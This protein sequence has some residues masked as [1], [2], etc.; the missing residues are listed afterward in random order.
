MVERGTVTFRLL[1]GLYQISCPCR[2]EPDDSRWRGG[3][4][5]DRDIAPPSGAGDL[6]MFL[7]PESE[8]EV[9]G[10]LSRQFQKIRQNEP[11]LFDH[12]GPSVGL[13]NEPWDVVAR[14]NPNARLGVPTGIDGDRTAQRLLPDGRSGTARGGSTPKPDDRASPKKA[15]HEPGL[16]KP[17]ERLYFAG[18]TSE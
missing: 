3:Y 2:R 16:R 9:V 17:A 10:G 8:R 11:H 1:T 7:G 18:T 13:D 14:G 4:E 5:R 12:R 15:G 6:K